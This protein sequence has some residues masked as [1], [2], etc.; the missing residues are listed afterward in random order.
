MDIVKIDIFNINRD[1]MEQDY[2]QTTAA[3]G[4][5]D[6]S[7]T[8]YHE[9]ITQL[10]LTLIDEVVRNWR[11]PA[12]DAKMTAVLFEALDDRRRRGRRGSSR[13]SFR[14]RRHLDLRLRVEALGAADDHEIAASHTAEDFDRPRPPNPQFDFAAFRL[15]TDYHPHKIAG[16]ELEDRF[17]GDDDGGEAAGGF[18]FGL[19]EH[20]GL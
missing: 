9:T 6:T 4:T 3:V 14:V 15:V 12:D 7:T 18:E 5:L 20:A 17:F 11:G 16:R 2:E 19:D 13:T 1:F 10:Y 8:G